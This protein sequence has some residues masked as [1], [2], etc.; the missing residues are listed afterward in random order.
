[1]CQL[2]LVI[3][4]LLLAASLGLVMSFLSSSMMGRVI[5][6]G[7][8]TGDGSKDNFSQI[9]VPFLSLDTKVGWGDF[10]RR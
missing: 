6:N 2:N 4:L 3:A 8:L 10:W 7:W 5:Y 1:M 9:F